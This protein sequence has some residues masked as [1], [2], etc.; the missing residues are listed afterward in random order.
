MIL[1]I[2]H[3]SS[4]V[5]VFPDERVLQTQ[6]CILFE[7]QELYHTSALAVADPVQCLGARSFKLVRHAQGP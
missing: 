7:N 1:L 3:V 6:F 4:D 5:T 2:L